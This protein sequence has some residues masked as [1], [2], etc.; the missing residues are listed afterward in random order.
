MLSEGRDR[1][2]REQWVKDVLNV[3]LTRETKL[4]C[5]DD[6]VVVRSPSLSVY[7]C[8]VPSTESEVS[9]G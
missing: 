7:S 1:V 3:L 2:H 8:C 4:N 9:G 6:T 5:T